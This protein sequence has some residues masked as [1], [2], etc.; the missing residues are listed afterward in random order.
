MFSKKINLKVIISLTL[1]A[2]TFSMYAQTKK[3]RA[4]FIKDSI[5]IM[6]V[7]LVRPQLRG[8]NRNLFY[9]NQIITINGLDAGVLLRDKLRLTLGYYA[10]VNNL[11]DDRKVVNGV[12]WERQLKL[13][14]IGFNTEIIY[15]NTRFL[16]LGLPVEFGYGRNSLQYINSLTKEAEIKESSGIFLTDFGLSMTF[17]PIRWIGVKGVVGYRKTLFN[18]VSNF[19]F[20]GPFASI[21]LNADIRE[22]IKDVQMFKLKKKYKKNLNSMET[23]IDLITD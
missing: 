14:Y 4:A 8:D 1:F 15:K 20:D 3:Q 21:G 18:Q 13:Q 11:K 7:K 6:R 17:K 22:V 2:C 19:H 12:D 10:T 9:K 16:T 23:A 5:Y